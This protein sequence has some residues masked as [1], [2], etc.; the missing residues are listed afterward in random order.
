M[1]GGRPQVGIHIDMEMDIAMQE[2]SGN[3][4]TSETFAQLEAMLEE[5]VV[6]MVAEAVQLVQAQKS[7]VFG[8]GEIFYRTAPGYWRQVQD[9]WND[10]YFPSLEPVLS[11]D[12]RLLRGGLT[13]RP[14][15]VE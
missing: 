14:I 6:G 5:K 8:L 4:T 11:A 10:E 3:L 15:P 2:C 13:I 1:A 9:G 7:D 12:V